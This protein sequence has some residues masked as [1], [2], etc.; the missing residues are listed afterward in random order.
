VAQV[1]VFVL[2]E[3]V[4]F[5][6]MNKLWVMLIVL[7]IVSFTF[8]SADVEIAEEVF[9]ELDDEGTVKVIVLI[10]DDADVKEV[11]GQDNK[12]IDSKEQSSLDSEVEVDREFLAVK[13]F[14]AEVTEQGLRQLEQNQKIKQ[15][16]IDKIKQLFLFDSVPLINASLTHA[17]QF[18]EINLTGVGQ[19]ICVIDTGVDYTHPDLGGCTTEQFLAGTCSKVIGGY[20]FVNDDVN[21]MDDVGHGTHVAGI[22]AAN[23]GVIGV[24]PQANI[25]A[26]KACDVDGCYNSN[27]ESSMRWCINNATKFNISVISM[28]LG[29]EELFSSYCDVYDSMIASL[30]D[31][32]TSQNIS[33]VVSTGNDGS[34]TGVG[35]PACITNVT[36]VGAST[37]GDDVAS[38]SNRATAFLD[39]ILAPGQG[40]VST[41]LDSNNAT[42]SGTSMSAPHVSGAVAILQQYSQIAENRTLNFTDV[43]TSII[44]S[45][46]VI[47][48]AE[49]GINFSRINVFSAYEYIKYPQIDLVNIVNNS[50]FNPQVINL[51]ISDVSGLSGAWYNNGTDDFVLN[52]ISINDWYINTTDWATG[53]WNVSVYAN[54]SV[55][56][57]SNYTYTFYLDYAPNVTSW[58]WNS[59]WN[60]DEVNSSNSTETLINISAKENGTVQFNMSFSDIDNLNNVNYSWYIDLVLVNNTANWTYN[61]NS[62]EGGYHNL[63][64]N[65][66][67]NYL[68]TL[69][70]WNLTIEDPY[71]PVWS[72]NLLA[73]D[74][75]GETSWSYDID[76]QLNNT[77]ADNLTYSCSHYS[78]SDGTI[79]NAF[80]CSGSGNYNI[81]V[82]VSDGWNLLEGNFTLTVL[83]TA[84]CTTTSSSSGGGGGGGGGG[85]STTSLLPQV[86]R[87]FPIVNADEQQILVVSNEQIPTTKVSYSIDSA[88]QNVRLSVKKL[89]EKPDEV[90]APVGVV[91]SYLEIDLTNFVG[92]VNGAEIEFYVTNS[93][94]LNN[95]INIDTLNLV[96]YTTS[97]HELDTKYIRENTTHTVFSAKSPGFSYFAIIGNKK[98]ASPKIISGAETAELERESLVLTSLNTN[99]K[100]NKFVLLVL[101]ALTILVLIY[102]I[103]SEPFKI[104]HFYETEEKKKR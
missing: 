84:V 66:S 31:N 65:V 29:S 4:V 48:D 43:E 9:E 14:S 16:R 46:V 56:I 87:I 21:P 52:S 69:I 57:F 6:Q 59:T 49:L 5:L 90:V 19:T 64:L 78:C 32:A 50:A 74:S 28:S 41:W 39:L 80:G 40:I 63:T 11:V 26:L 85:S 1:V 7:I 2:Q 104:M 89:D 51:T 62:A 79:S 88:N 3:S 83:D 97:W 100:E 91:H 30:V 70:N 58:E 77:D 102:H 25:V 55:N 15:V 76:A 37:N 17:V 71:P 12:L 36:R 34:T 20:D 93:W 18:L 27:I 10:D 98:T 23:G 73:N 92:V 38:F 24:A 60:S 33:V 82:N 22:V 103:K 67:D 95:N 96:R 68:D 86:S 44:N 75:V 35:S 45:G 42:Y 94:L 72:N 99:L 81:Y 47:Y 54:D 101:I 8:V 53:E 13:G 61:I